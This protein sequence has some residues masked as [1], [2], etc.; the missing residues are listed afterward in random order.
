M[1]RVRF[2]ISSGDEAL[3][4]ARNLSTLIDAGGGLV[5]AQD[6]VPIPALHQGCREGG[7]GD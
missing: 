5:S 3:F 1:L 4:A 6:Q 7:C 2:A